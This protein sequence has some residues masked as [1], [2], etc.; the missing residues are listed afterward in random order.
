MRS[1]D[2]VPLLTAPDSGPSAGFRQ[3]TIVTWNQATAA[4]TVLVGRSLMTNLPILNTSEAAILQ[5]GDVVGILTAGATWG[6][7][8]RFTI[9]GTPEAVSA[10]SAL[11]TASATVAAAETTSSSSFIDLPTMGP[12]VELS[13]GPSGRVLVTLSC[14]MEY[15]ALEGFG[16][17]SAGAMMGFAGSGANTVSVSVARVVRSRIEYSVA[18][19]SDFA[20][21]GR[22]DASRVVLLTGLTP[23]LTTFTAKYAT[24]GNT[25]SATFSNRNITVQAI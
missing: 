13:V 12:S 20:L 10:L 19:V 8:G 15:Q 14:L 22:M 23:G 24:Y 3:G 7:L 17:N 25:P 6:I 4:N 9:P 2:L 21:A 1:D 11:R 16:L 5:A 18:N